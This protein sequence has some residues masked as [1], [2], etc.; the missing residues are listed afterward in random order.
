ME[1][2]K[3]LFD[4]LHNFRDFGGY[5]AGGRKMAAG[6]FFRSANHAAASDAD[7]AR[8]R[9]MGIG[10]VID[11]RRPSERERQPS[12]RWADFSGIVIENDDHDEGAETWDV[13]M[14]S[15][16]MTEE[17]FRGYMMRYY[18]RAPHTPRLVELYRRYF[19][20]LAT[21]EG[22]LVVHCAAGKDRTGLIVALTHML[23]GVH[24]DDVVADYL[25]TNDPARFEAFGATWAEAIRVERGFGPSLETM[26][27]VMGVEP[28][29]LER[30]LQV[31]T[32]RDG[33][34][35]GYLRDVLGVDGGKRA[36]IEKRLFG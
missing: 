26:R 19:D 6:R 1:T 14:S 28:A 36:A 25:L 5:D 2:R 3:H 7:L 10:A 22:A 13:F 18:T 27:M 20:V 15:W 9:E 35:E 34:V 24:R 21:G 33:G 12:R 16:D 31:I 30:S 23:A 11:L 29:Y 17:S 32:E 4:G 8:L